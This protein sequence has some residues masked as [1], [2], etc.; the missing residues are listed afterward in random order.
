MSGGPWKISRFQ[1]F[2]QD[3]RR[4]GKTHYK[5][6][7]SGRSDFEKLVRQIIRELEL[8][9]LAR[10]LPCGAT[11]DEERYPN[12]WASDRCLLRKARFPLPNQRG[13]ARFGRIH[14]EVNSEKWTV[15]FVTVYTHAEH[16]V[17]YDEPTLIRRLRQA[18]ESG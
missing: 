4:L 15:T 11:C 1:G 9:P 10:K 16:P 2:D 7:R 6:D 8:D 5:K 3:I 17:N 18:R 14:F 12:G 13:A